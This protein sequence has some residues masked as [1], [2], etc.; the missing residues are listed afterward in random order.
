MLFRSIDSSKEF[1]ESGL[2]LKE[3]IDHINSYFNYNHNVFINSGVCTVCGELK[4][5][6]IEGHLYCT[7]WDDGN[8]AVR[9]DTK[10]IQKAELKYN[11]LIL[12]LKNGSVL[13]IS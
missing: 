6:D 2:T 8:D 10:E 4:C 7:L 5:D 9:F 12:T 3:T 13:K 1:D 11:V